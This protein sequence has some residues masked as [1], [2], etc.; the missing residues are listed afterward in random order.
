MEKMMRAMGQ[1]VP[2]TKRVFELN[3]ENPLVSAMQ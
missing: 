3:P 1:Q 2:K